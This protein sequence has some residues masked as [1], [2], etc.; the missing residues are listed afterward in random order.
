MEKSDKI[1]KAISRWGTFAVVDIARRL[2]TNAEETESAKLLSLFVV[3]PLT[4]FILVTRSADREKIC[5]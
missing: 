1:Q 2:R 4:N 3:D 5:T